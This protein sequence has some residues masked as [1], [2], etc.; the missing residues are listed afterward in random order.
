MNLNLLLF[1]I[2]NGTYLWGR[3]IKMQYY[4]IRFRLSNVSDTF[5]MGGKSILSSDLSA[6]DYSYLGP[7]CLICPKVKIGRYSMIANNVS[8]IGSDHIYTDATQPIIFSGR[9]NLK[10]TII[11]EDVWVG[12]FSIIMTGVEIG[13][14]AIVGAGSVVTKDIPPYSVFAGVPAKFI[15]MRFN[16]D[17][18]NTHI[19][20]LKSKNVD[21]KYCSNK[22]IVS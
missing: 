11:G 9:P 7:N 6:A 13:N 22:I 17:E 19:N 3:N 1:T 10:E 21:V 4:R 8:V 16:D 15:K 20:M 12:A 5:Y 2:K 14:G 18:I